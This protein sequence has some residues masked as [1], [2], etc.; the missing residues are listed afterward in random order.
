M[1]VREFIKA[2]NWET[3]KNTNNPNEYNGWS[4]YETWLFN[5]EVGYDVMQSTIEEWWNIIKNGAYE[6]PEEAAWQL[7]I[8]VRREMKDLIEIIEEEANVKGICQS[9]LRSGFQSIDVN[10]LTRVYCIDYA[11]DR[12]ES[13]W[14]PQHSLQE[15]AHL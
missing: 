8:N 5:L 14:Q 11:N 10:E 7:Y 1:N 12:G 13:L 9:L 2:S 6:T 15:S 4:N 3:P